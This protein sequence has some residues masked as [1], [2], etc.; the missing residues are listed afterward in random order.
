MS[1]TLPADLFVDLRQPILGDSFGWAGI[2]PA[3]AKKSVVFHH[4]GA[5]NAPGE[6]AFSIADYHVNHNGWGGGGYHFVITRSDYPG[7]PGFTSPGAQIQ[8]MGDLNTYRA[9]VLNQNP[10][11]VGVCFVGNEPD[12]NQLRLGRTLMDFFIAKNNVLP[13]I[14]YGNQAT[15]HQLVPGQSTACPGVTFPTW[16][17][18]IQG[19]AWPYDPPVVATPVETRVDPLSVPGKGGAPEWEASYQPNPEVLPVQREGAQAV[20]VTT[21]QVVVPNVPVG[22]MLDIA[23][24]FTHAEHKYARTVYSVAHGKWNGIDVTYLEPP[25]GTVNAEITPTVTTNDAQTLPQGYQLVPETEVASGVT[26]GQSVPETSK[27]SLFQLFRRFIKEVS[28]RLTAKIIK[29][30]L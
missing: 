21:S 1:V 9:H 23:G 20:D 11:R 8:Y 29:R 12:E 14:N 6:D 19:G 5:E 7:R 30:K 15:V 24:Y 4:S 22:Q 28:A 27:L 25:T 18:Y 10:G 17:P 13:S 16:L 26:D 3:A 2:E